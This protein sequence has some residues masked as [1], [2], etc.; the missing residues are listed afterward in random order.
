MQTCKITSL[1]EQIWTKETRICNATNPHKTIRD[2]SLSDIGSGEPLFVKLFIALHIKK[3]HG[4][5]GKYAIRT[6]KTDIAYGIIM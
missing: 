2:T 6:F 1:R 3:R 5:C 4:G